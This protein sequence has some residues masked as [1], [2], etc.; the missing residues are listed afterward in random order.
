MAGGMLCR[1]GGTGGAGGLPHAGLPA[2]I[3]KRWS[4]SPSAAPLKVSGKAPGSRWRKQRLS[5]PPRATR[6]SE[7][8]EGPPGQ[9]P[10]GQ[11]VALR[12]LRLLPGGPGCGVT[13]PPPPPRARLA[14][15]RR[16]NQQESKP[17]ARPLLQSPLVTLLISAFN[18]VAF[19]SSGEAGEAG[20]QA[21]LKDTI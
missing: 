21:L 5:S 8:R 18:K 4:R 20:F 2:R 3:Y 6:L 17:A 16:A 15:K 14:V 11:L 13:P 7:R 12:G 1:R 9:P 19:N 10:L